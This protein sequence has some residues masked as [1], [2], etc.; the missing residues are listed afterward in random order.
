MKLASLK[1]GRDGRLVVVSSDLAWYADAGH[2]APTLRAALEDWERIAPALE[3]LATDLAHEAIP[4]ERFHEHDAAAP[5]P[6]VVLAGG[7]HRDILGARD[8]TPAGGRAGA[9]VIVVTG[10][11]AAGATREAALAAVR[12]I[13]L[14][15]RMSGH[16][17]A[18]WTFSPVFVTPD[19][20][21][22]WW[23]DG[24]LH[25]RVN[26]DLNDVA[27]DRIEAGDADLGAAVARAAAAGPLA[28]GTIVAAGI[29]RD[30]EAL[31]DGDTVRI[32]A[33][34]DR[35]HPIFGAIEQVAAA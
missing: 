10:D 13:G 29:A 3:L 7:E 15:N 5:L 23:R 30:G 11:V 25:R 4:L 33:E 18:A 6:Q 20:L 27:V 24:A 17:G 16:A 22:E 14:A 19:A 8:A 12:L 26:L 21:G 28:T 1:H 2:I 32:W 9:E 31:T 34:D 35:H